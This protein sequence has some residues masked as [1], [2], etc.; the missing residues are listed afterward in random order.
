[1]VSFRNLATNVHHMFR[2]GVESNHRISV[3]EPVEGVPMAGATRGDAIKYA[4]RAALLE[5]ES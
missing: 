5:A 3:A 1:V 2:F 4:I